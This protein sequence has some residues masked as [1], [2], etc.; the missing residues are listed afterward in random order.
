MNAIKGTDSYESSSSAMM[1]DEAKCMTLT[2]S[3]DQVSSMLQA[4][5][6]CMR[7]NKELTVVLKNLLPMIKAIASQSQIL[8]KQQL[9]ISRTLFFIKPSI[10]LNVMTTKN[11]FISMFPDIEHDW[12]AYYQKMVSQ[13]ILSFELI[14]YLI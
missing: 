6:T 13:I 2:D 11:A 14:I 3:S 12:T 7:L 10:F 9:E 1:P 4:A 5:Q 8:R